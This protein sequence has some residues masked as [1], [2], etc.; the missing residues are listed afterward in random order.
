MDHK[1]TIAAIATPPGEGAIAIIRL[2]GPAAFSIAK[3][4][5][6]SP[7]ETFAS[8]TAHYGRI[9][10][11]D[12]STLDAVL[13]IIMKAPRSYTGE[14]TVEI[15]CHGGSF[16][17]QRILERV[18]EA[19]ARPARPGEFSLRAYLNGKLDLAQAEA[20]QQ[21][22]AAKSTM[23]LSTAESQLEGHLSQC[24]AEFQKELIDIAAILEAWVDFPEEGLEFASMEEIV[25]RL[26]ATCS[27]MERLSSTFHQGQ[28][29]HQ[30][31]SLCLLGAPNVGKS[32]LMN[33]LL[34]KERAIVTEIA[35]TTRDL[36]EED[37]CLGPLHFRLIDTAGI[38]K[39]EERIEQEGI[40]RS[41]KAMEKAD[42]ILL[43]LDATRPLSLDDHQL[44]AMAP[45]TKTVLVWNKIDVQEPQDRS[46]WDTRTVCISARERV[47]LDDLQQEIETH[48]K[49]Q[50]LPSKEEIVITRQRHHSALVQAIEALQMVI[51]GLKQNVS[52]EFIISDLRQ[53]LHALGTILGIHVSEEILSAIFSKFCLGK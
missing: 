53:A 50:G 3:K 25:A 31:I 24:I 22:I 23:A 27:R 33:A 29:L 16:I 19:G 12:G 47:G 51:R 13:L 46:P 40:R 26:D 35:G 5:F 38:R 7:V 30:G 21:L 37:F 34:G 9:L 10:A 17:T 52:A 49:E 41:H 28:R 32:S 18:V 20:V 45:R 1:D 39:T 36:L 4:I 11:K 43:L 44:L 6:T 48:F 42:L 8:H 2:S 14:D 15:S